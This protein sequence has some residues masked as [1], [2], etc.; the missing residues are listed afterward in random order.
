VKGKIAVMLSLMILSLLFT[1]TTVLAVEETVKIKFYF[2]E[3]GLCLVTR[4]DVSSAL[5]E[6]M[7]DGA[8]ML[9]GKADGEYVEQPMDSVVLKGYLMD[10]LAARGA[11]LL[12][13]T[14]TDNSK[15]WVSVTFYS[16]A[17]SIGVYCYDPVVIGSIS[18]ASAN[19]NDYIRFK[20][21]YFDGSEIQEI[22][23]VAL[24]MIIQFS[25]EGYVIAMQLRDDTL[26]NFWEHSMFR[27]IWSNIDIVMPEI[28][29][30]QVFRWN[31]EI[32]P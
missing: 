23:G 14:E 26:P 9:C 17:T 6:G 20:G 24:L 19:P 1:S 32:K 11:L 8:L 30:A 12:R 13:W 15:R 3:T 5:W 21:T 4:G 16:T 10:N 28:P 25:E 29:A 7:G 18:M 22:T 31:V 2:I 27:A